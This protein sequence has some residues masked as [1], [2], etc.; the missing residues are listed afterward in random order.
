MRFALVD[1][2]HIALEWPDFAERLWPAVRQD[3]GY[4][5]EGLRKR[6]LTGHAVLFE[7]TDGANGLLVVLVVPEGDE[8]VAW[9]TAIAGKIDGGPKARIAVMREAIASIESVARNA[10]C[11][12]HRICG[13][14]YSRLFPDYQ[15]FEGHR[16]GL[17]KRL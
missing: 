3:P 4:S 5:L 6:L 12:A 7:V 2:A 11:V 16:N 1:Q 9:T 14:D 13:R 10:G 8:L 15:P 17:E